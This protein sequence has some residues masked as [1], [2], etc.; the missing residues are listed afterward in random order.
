[1]EDF[2]VRALLSGIGIALATG[3]LGVFVVWRRMAYFGDALSHASLLGVALGLITGVNMNVAIALVCLT[4]ALLVT[5]MQSRPELPTDAALGIF[6]HG[7]L[8]LGLIA[9][10]L[11]DGVRVDLMA[12]LFGDVLAAG[13]SDVAWIWTGAG[14]V[15]VVI[16]RYWNDWVNATVHEGLAQLDGVAVVRMRLMFMLLTALVTAA[17]LKVVGALLITALLVIPAAAARPLA[18]TP[19]GMAAGAILIGTASTLFGLMASYRWDL[20]SGPAIVLIA[21]GWFGVTLAASKGRNLFRSSSAPVHR[22]PR[23]TA[24]PEC[25]GNSR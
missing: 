19:E 16:H 12:Y 23:P 20:P 3:P 5:W 1:M 25:D 4:V 2:M 6:S 24:A 21:C 17:A 13:W 8:A 7:A 15:G 9:T 11:T 10:A 18:S 22:T 14:L